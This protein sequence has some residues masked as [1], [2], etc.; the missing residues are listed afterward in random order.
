ML[1]ISTHTYVFWMMGFCLSIPLSFI[2]GALFAYKMMA[3]AII[4]P[5]DLKLVLKEDKDA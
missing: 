5:S 4:E 2:A 1:F 3:G